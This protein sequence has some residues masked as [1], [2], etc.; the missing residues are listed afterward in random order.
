GVGEPPLLL[1]ASVFY[2]IK[3]AIAAARADA[4][5]GQ[6]FRLDSPA[7]VERIRMACHDFITK[8]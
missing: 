6:V 4:G 8:E 7:T 2:A 1:A 3:D 5:L